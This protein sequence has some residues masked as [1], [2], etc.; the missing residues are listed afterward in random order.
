[1]LRITIIVFCLFWSNPVLAQEKE[2]SALV[3]CQNYFDEQLFDNFC[4]EFSE[5]SQYVFF[6]DEKKKTFF[7]IVGENCNSAVTIS[8]NLN[9]FY[10]SD[11]GGIFLMEELMKQNVYLLSDFEWADPWTCLRP[12]LILIYVFEF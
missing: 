8:E 9:E 2:L 10:Q 12:G 3:G 5:G 7:I 6:A 1:M 11:S 4:V